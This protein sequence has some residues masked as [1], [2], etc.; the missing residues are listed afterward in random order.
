MML[1]SCH[2]IIILYNLMNMLL[3][4]YTLMLLNY[5]IALLFYY[6]VIVLICYIRFYPCT[7]ILHEYIIIL[8][9]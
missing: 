7:V 5:Y 8:L 1:L 3:Y 4:D 2:G 9:D 6:L